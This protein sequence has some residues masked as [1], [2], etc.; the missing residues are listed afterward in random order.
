MNNFAV[1]LYVIVSVLVTGFALYYFLKVLIKSKAQGAGGLGGW[2]SKIGLVLAMAGNAIGLGNFLRFPV[3][4]INNGGGAFIIPYLVCFVLIGIPLLFVEWSMGRFAG[5]PSPGRGTGD[6]NI[7]FILQRM[8][9]ARWIK[10]AGVFGIFINVAVAGYYCYIESWTL[11]YAYHSLKGSFQG[12]SQVEV[13]NFFD[14]YTTYF[15]PGG[16]GSYEAIWFYLIC[17]GINVYFLSRGLKG[18][19]ELVAKIGMPLLILFGIILAF[20]TLTLRPGEKGAVFAGIDGI[21]YLWT[22]DYSSIW[23][24]SVWI[25]AA[26]Q[27]FFTLAVGMA[28][29]QCYASYMKANEDTALGA[30]SAGWMNEFVEVVLGSAIIIPITVGY[31]GVDKMAEMVKS[32]GGY[33]LGFKTIP[34]LFQQWGTT[35]AAISGVMWFGL[36]FI[37]GITSSLA[38]GTPIIGF[39]KDEFNI[40]FK[41]GAMIF[42]ALVLIMGFPT[43]IY[44]NEGVFT[45]FDDWAGTYALV[46]FAFIELIIFGWMFGMKR[47]WEEITRGAQIHVPI[48]FRYIIQ[49]ITPT[50]LGIILISNLKAM[51]NRVIHPQNG[52]A[53]FAQLYLLGLFLLILTFIYI[54]SQ[55][56]KKQGLLP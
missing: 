49:F 11:A 51:V 46:I 36:L 1:L 16:G 31:L 19:I 21:R 4:A 56:R 33:G 26:G 14:N 32:I 53:T 9:V 45:E 12:L 43:I 44:Y 13:G 7:P 48:I 17:V 41:S 24:P 35:L 18:G 38:M 50:I 20:E 3:Q 15:S 8:S 30:M 37:A 28:S 6:H 55:R 40:S 5:I 23:K 22:P 25:A 2:G 54:A 39:L 42:G 34:F 52:Y 29:I 47:G 10:Y 27:I